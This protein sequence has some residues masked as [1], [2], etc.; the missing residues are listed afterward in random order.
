[1]HQHDVQKMHMPNL[2]RS[3]TPPHGP[4]SKMPLR[5]AWST[6]NSTPQR[7]LSHQIGWT[8]AWE[9]SSDYFLSW[10]FLTT[11]YMVL[12]TQDNT[13]QTYRVSLFKFFLQPILDRPKDTSFD[14]KKGTAVHR[15]TTHGRRRNGAAGTSFQ[16]HI[17]QVRINALPLQGSCHQIE[18][19]LGE[20]TMWSPY[21]LWIHGQI[22]ADW[23][24]EVHRH[25]WG[26]LLGWLMNY[27]LI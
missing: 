8:F 20:V 16:G 2:S 22:M 5:M 7:F 27:N 23:A 21:G 4:F 9:K 18:W 17:A 14:L 25:T 12:T 13:W 19:V 15:S 6:I 10:G 24:G 3:H 11:K 1:M 26:L